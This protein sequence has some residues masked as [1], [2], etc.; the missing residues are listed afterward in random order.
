VRSGGEFEPTAGKIVSREEALSRAEEWRA[1]GKTVVYTNG[2]FDL[3][4]GGHVRTLESARQKGDVL[5]VGVNADESVRRLKGRDRPIL[6]ERERAELVAALAC[7]DLVVIF[8]EV[9]SLKVLEAV[10]PDVWAKGGDWS[11]ATLNQEERAFVEGYGG[12]VELG[13]RVAGVSTSELIERMK[14]LPDD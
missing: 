9:T 4:H 3:L 6:A 8:P 14:R 7:V 11:L 1:E 12:R 10:R 13:E 5:I 2:C